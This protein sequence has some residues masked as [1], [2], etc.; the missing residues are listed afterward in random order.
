MYS[1][2]ASSAKAM[3]LIFTYFTIILQL[4]CLLYLLLLMSPVT[5]T[6]FDFEQDVIKAT[7]DQWSKYQKLYVHTGGKHFNICSEMYFH[8]CVSSECF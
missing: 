7:V 3:Y 6:P 1:I 4:I 2:L 8:L 5:Q